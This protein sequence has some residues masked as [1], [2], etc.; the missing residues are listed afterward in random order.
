MAHLFRAKIT[1]TGFYVPER[2]VPNSELQLHINTTDEWIQERTGIKER[3]FF[4]EGTDTVSK[5]G[6]RASKIALEKA[7]L[8]AKDIDM[9]LFATLS[10]DYYFPGSGVVMLRELG[11]AEIPAL[12]IRMQCSGFVYGLSV[13]DQYI[14]TGM[15]KKILVVGGEIQSNIFELSDRG[16]TMA[17][18]FGDGAG[19]VVVEATDA[20][21]E[22][23]ILST[24]LHSDG[25]FA[26]ELM[27]QHPSSNKKVRLTSEMLD[28]GDLLPYMNGQLVFK[29]AVKRFPEVIKEAL[30]KN[31][32]TIDDLDLL[33][34]H[35]ANI[36]IA[37]YVQ[38]SMGLPAEKVYNNIQKYG[39]TTA[40][41]IP[42]ALSEAIEMGKAKKGDLVCMAAFGSGFTWASALVKWAY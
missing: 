27:Q 38:Q 24:H 40:A 11:L 1:G 21:D 34:P 3:R 30:D 2:V 6:A 20:D 23:V 5:M 28:N 7:G 18:I 36:R 8:E 19:A 10:P 17:V 41:S 15:Y 25:R 26:E 9:V 13:A 4:E 33:I 16:R 37:E 31:N 35:Q 39:N 32:Y 14:R 12:D 29:H 42:I 22:N